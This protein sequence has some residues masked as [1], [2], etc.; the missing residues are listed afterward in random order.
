[1]WALPQPIGQLLLQDF[2]ASTLVSLYLDVEGLIVLAAVALLSSTCVAI[3]SS[4]ASVY[5]SSFTTRIG[6]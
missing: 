4:S 2:F 3:V 5:G 1:M 6:A